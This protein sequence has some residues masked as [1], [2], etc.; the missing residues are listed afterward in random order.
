MFYETINHYS[1]W[2]F[3]SMF[4]ETL[5]HYSVS[6][7][8][9]I[10]L[11]NLEVWRIYIHYSK[12]SLFIFFFE[13]LLSI[14]YFASINPPPLSRRPI[15]LLHI[16]RTFSRFQGLFKQESRGHHWVFFGLSYPS[17]VT[18]MWFLRNWGFS[19]PNG[20]GI[21]NGHSCRTS[22]MYTGLFQNGN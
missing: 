1:I 8:C 21:R 20:E 19:S 5:I 9:S 12:C 11:F 4:Y 2:K 10:F 16:Q 14:H 17:L 22:C 7:F 18:G 6:K 13:P 15:L 3:C